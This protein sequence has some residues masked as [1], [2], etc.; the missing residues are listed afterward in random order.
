MGRRRRATKAWLKR[1]RQRF[2]TWWNQQ[3]GRLEG[4]EGDQEEERSQRPAHDIE[5]QPSS[6]NS[7]L[8][9][10]TSSHWTS[11]SDNP[12][13]SSPA[14][15][16]QHTYHPFLHPAYKPLAHNL[17][18][19][20]WDIIM[21]L[22]L[23]SH[24]YVYVTNIKP[25]LAFCIGEYHYPLWHFPKGLSF[26]DRCNRVNW[27][28]HSAGGISA[29]GAMFLALWHVCALVCR[30]WGGV[31]EGS[32]RRVKSGRMG[33]W[34]KKLK[35]RRKGDA[36]DDIGMADWQYPPRDVDIRSRSSLRRSI[37][38]GTQSGTQAGAEGG[39]RR[40]GT[41][42][43][44]EMGVG[45]TQRR[46]MRKEKSDA[47]SDRRKESRGSRWSWQTEGFFECLA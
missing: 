3:W 13:S 26:Q 40:E 45:M 47:G 27:G 41:L 38:S 11:D 2:F 15:L 24:I 8:R 42:G 25:G 16:A 20:L 19:S 46:K 14:S 9:N 39:E 10:G 31:G 18:L 5:R 12:P 1:L 22:T 43:R 4:R 29:T 23:A 32:I 28:I 30:F 35:G 37:R 17:L 21:F 7:T 33:K 36:G 44:E 6:R 34:K